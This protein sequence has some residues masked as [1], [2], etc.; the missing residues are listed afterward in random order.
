MGGSVQTRRFHATGLKRETRD[1]RRFIAV[2]LIIRFF[3]FFG[4]AESFSYK[5]SPG[6][7]KYFYSQRL[8]RMSA[9]STQF[10]IERCLT[11]LP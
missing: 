5:N 10:D 2:G 9:N 7:R 8:D 4:L 6:K 11:S 1:Y 3:S